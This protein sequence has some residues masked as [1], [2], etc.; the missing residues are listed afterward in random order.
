MTKTVC[1]IGSL[2]G[3]LIAFR[4]PLLAAI[5]HAGHRV[6]AM[7]PGI[8]AEIA[9][10]LVAIGVEPRSI[11][12]DRNGLSVS[13]DIETIR[14]LRRVLSEVKA[15]VVLGYT[16]KP[17][18]YGSLAASWAGVPARYAMITGLGY[19]FLNECGRKQRLVGAA[20]RLLY[21]VSL[22]L[23][24]RVFFQNPDDRALF[25][26]LRLLR[27]PEQAVMINGSGVDLERFRPA[28]L[29][30]TPS[31]LLIARLLKDK[32]LR[33]YVE[34]AR[35]LRARYP[36][37]RF[38][39]V[40][41]IDT[42]PTAICPREFQSWL[43]EGVIEYLGGKEDVR[44]AIAAAS[45]Y[46]LPSYR[47]GTPRTILEAMAMGRPVVTTDA[48]GCRETVR[49]GVNGY[50]VPVR[51]APALADAIERLILEPERV[52]KMG[53]ESRRIA[54][55]KYDVHRVN[56]VVLKAMELV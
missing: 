48:P 44:P 56:E 33:E 20:A 12:L 43:D 4:G 50:L 22:H 21:R 8:D 46:V 42:N 47:E 16:I 28:P 6:V 51:D 26:R 34:A 54:E 53:R 11:P 5:R 36:E 18:V 49:D 35:M 13:R 25:E 31:F 45:A 37:V 7:A 24:E 1:V 10:K 41:S 40:G 32:G 27:R 30:E 17:V 15:E 14:V 52:I 38:R 19:S 2:A 23:N 55:A 39:L 9:S 3:S 29:P